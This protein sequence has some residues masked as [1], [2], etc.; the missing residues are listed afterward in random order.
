MYKYFCA[1]IGTTCSMFVITMIFVCGNHV[2][3]VC[4]NSTI[5]NR[6]L[7]RLWVCA[8]DYCIQNINKIPSDGFG[9]DEC[10]LYDDVGDKGFNDLC[11]PLFGL[12]D[13]GFK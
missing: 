9:F 4:D 6:I 13:F 5:Y 8:V 11:L 10:E 7:Y 3:C 2:I 12:I 1:R